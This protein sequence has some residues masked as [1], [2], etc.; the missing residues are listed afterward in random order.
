MVAKIVNAYGLYCTVRSVQLT[1]EY[2]ASILL[3]LCLTQHN[4]RTSVD[5]AVVNGT[6]ALMHSTVAPE[7]RIMDG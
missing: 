1:T 7:C 6:T 2:F 5:Q 3:L 4:Y